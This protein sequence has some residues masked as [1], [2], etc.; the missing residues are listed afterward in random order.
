MKHLSVV[1]G[2]NTV[3]RF[4]LDPHLMIGAHIYY[5]FAPGTHKMRVRGGVRVKKDFFLVDRQYTDHRSLRQELRRAVDRRYRERGILRLEFQKNHLS[6][7]V[8]TPVLKGL[9]YRYSF[10]RYLCPA[11]LKMF[12]ALFEF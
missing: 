1:D 12:Y 5:F 10:G 9:H 3:L 8:I 2:E 7:R 6:R 11:V 4:Q